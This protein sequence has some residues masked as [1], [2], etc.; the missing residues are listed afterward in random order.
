MAVNFKFHPDFSQLAKAYGIPDY[1]LET[2]DDVVKFL[3]KALS[4]PG[5]TF[6]N[7]V[8]PSDENVMPMVLAGKGIDEPIDD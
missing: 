2:E 3:P 5:P 1:T 8:V 4:D 7:C 6:I